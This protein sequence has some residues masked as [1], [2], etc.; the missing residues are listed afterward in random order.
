M[1][2]IEH[3]LIVCI[4][5]EGMSETVMDVAKEVLDFNK[6]AISFLGSNTDIDIEKIMHS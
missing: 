3:E 2:K 1:K 6:S 4:V 5:N